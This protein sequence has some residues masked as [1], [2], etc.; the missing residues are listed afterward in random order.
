[1]RREIHVEFR[2]GKH[3]GKIPPGRPSIG[4]EELDLII[5]LMIGITGR[6]L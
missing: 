3:K 4:W 5:L 6:M 1:V 2:C